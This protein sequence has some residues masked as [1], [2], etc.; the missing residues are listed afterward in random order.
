MIVLG[1]VGMIIIFAMQILM[2]RI[3][4]YTTPYAVIFR[5]LQKT[6]YN[7]LADIHCPNPNSEIEECKTSTRS[8]AGV[9]DLRYQLLEKEEKR[10]PLPILVSLLGPYKL[11]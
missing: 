9:P 2:G 11:D 6:S 5:A 10:F 4:Q 1:M 7:I 8:L 3:N